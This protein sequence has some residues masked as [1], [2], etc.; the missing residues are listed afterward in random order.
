VL[1]VLIILAWFAVEKVVLIC[2]CCF[3]DVAVLILDVPD[4]C[5][6]VVAGIVVVVVN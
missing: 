2:C 1:D 3:Y 5:V 6:L 4:V